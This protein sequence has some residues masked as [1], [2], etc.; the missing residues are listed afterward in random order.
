MTCHI[1]ALSE[2]LTINVDNMAQKDNL[3]I[4]WPSFIEWFNLTLKQCKSSI[5]PLQYLTKGKKAQ[6]QRIVNELGTK[7]VL[8]D[9]VKKMALSNLLNGRRRTKEFPNGF[10]ASFPWLTFNNERIVDVANG[11]YDNPPEQLLTPEEMWQ[12]EKEK[13]A[14]EREQRR[15]EALRIE[16]EEREARRRQR[17]YDAAHAATPEE[18]ERILAGNPLP[19]L[20]P[21]ETKTI[22]ETNMETNYR[23]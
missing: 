9:A 23:N 8:M 21:S 4:V 2:F 3:K 17:E 6:V 5:E 22:M 13:R 16:E 1:L 15:A 11:L 20:K 19:K 10:I 18:I 14:M 12:L 7:K